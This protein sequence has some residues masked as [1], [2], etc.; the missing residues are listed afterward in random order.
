MNITIFQGFL[1]VLSEVFFALIPLLVFFIFF[2]IFFLRLSR[3]KVIDTL[4]GFVL[5]F[6]GLSLFLQGVNI[7]FLP[8]GEMMGERLGALNSQWLLIPIGFVLGFFATY[9]EPA[10][11]IL[12]HQVE[13]VSAGYIPQRILLYTVSIGVGL[14]MA[15]SMV[16]ILL[17]I[18]LWYFILPGYLLVFW[19]AKNSSKLFTAIA[20]DSGGIV[21]GP[22][23]ATFLLAMFVGIATVIDGRD[24]MIDGFGMIALVALA[25]IL[26]VLVLGRLYKQNGGSDDA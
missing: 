23:I 6:I 9:A 24:P 3:R 12:I 19:L 2:Q 8:T 4:V 13:K 20:F 25:P 7:G 16:R 14:S 17:G 11:T 22:M 21:T 1:A 5:T 15:L 26:S 18:S 10:V